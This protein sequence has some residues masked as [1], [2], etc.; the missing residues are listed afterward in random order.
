MAYGDLI[1][2]SRL[3]KESE[4]IVNLAEMIVIDGF[5]TTSTELNAIAEGKSYV[6]GN[7]FETVP[8]DGY[9]YLHITT[10]E[11]IVV[12]SYQ[13]YCDALVYYGFYPNPIIE[14]TGVRIEIAPRN[15]VTIIEPTTMVGH[16]PQISDLRNPLVLRTNAAVSGPSKGGT[17][18]G[19]SRTVVIPPFRDAVIAVQNKATNAA[20]ISIVA[21]FIEVEEIRR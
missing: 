3:I 18:G 8:A 16:T 9:V 12:L 19:D 5:H 6:V 7:I 13:V 10:R 11:N 20:L 4:E 14:N 2:K 17:S 1:H 21:D 15:L